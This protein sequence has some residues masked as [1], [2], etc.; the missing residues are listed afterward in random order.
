V[1]IEFSEFFPSNTTELGTALEKAT[2]NIVA[3]LYPG[4]ALVPM[5][6]GGVTDGRYWRQR[7]SRVIGFTLYDREMTLSRFAGMIHGINERVSIESLQR[8]LEYFYRLPEEFYK[9]DPVA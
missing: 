5:F 7:G 8:T 2:E 3:D 4:T 1:L 9:L 6:V